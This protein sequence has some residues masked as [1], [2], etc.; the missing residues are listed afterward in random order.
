MD[1]PPRGVG[2]MR[3]VTRPGGA[4]AVNVWDF[5]EGMTAL[6]RFWDAAAIVA[7]EAAAEYDQGASHRYRSRG[8]LEELLETA[9]VAAIETGELVV[10][11]EYA[12]FADYWEPLLVPEG[13]PGRF[14]ATLDEAERVAIHDELR[15]RLGDPRGPFRLDARAWYARGAA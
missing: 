13:T 11:A 5:A 14:L 2:E 8:D 4:I 3:R 9:E 12:D 15:A 10:S 1:D 7:P 6:R